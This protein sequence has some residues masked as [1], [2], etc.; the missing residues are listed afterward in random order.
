MGARAKLRKLLIANNDLTLEV[1]GHRNVKNELYDTLFP[2]ELLCQRE[3]R[4]KWITL[5]VRRL[6]ALEQ[7]GAR[8]CPMIGLSTISSEVTE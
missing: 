7:H 8:K 2:N 1:A 3:V 5:E 6:K 4:W